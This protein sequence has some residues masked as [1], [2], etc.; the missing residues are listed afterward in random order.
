MSNAYLKGL[1]GNGLVPD[2]FVKTTWSK[3]STEVK[4]FK[5][6]EN[7]TQVISSRLEIDK[8]GL[9]FSGINMDGGKSRHI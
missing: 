3:F 5:T 1:F 4:R 9:F 7:W 8:K 2:L 6:G